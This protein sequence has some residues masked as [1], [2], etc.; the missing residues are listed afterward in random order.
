MCSSLLF[1]YFLCC[2]YS[3]DG[4][5]CVVAIA[6]FLSSVG[7]LFL[8]IVLADVVAVDDVPDVV[9]V[10]AASISATTATTSWVDIYICIYI[11]I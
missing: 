5:V 10:V 11:Y 7:C 2:C 3:L 9:V 4:F 8:D 6:C 1:A